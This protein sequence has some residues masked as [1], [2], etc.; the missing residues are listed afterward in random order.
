MLQ[1]NCVHCSVVPRFTQVPWIDMHTL[2]Y[3]V[4]LE[5]F[6][7]RGIL[8]DDIETMLLRENNVAAYFMPHGKSVVLSF[9]VP[10]PLDT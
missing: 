1:L 8:V 5:R 9:L 4:L 10:A 3:R 2:S 7:A 6:I